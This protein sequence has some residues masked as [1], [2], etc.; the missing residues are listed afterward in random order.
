MK[1]RS[2][3]VALLFK[4]GSLAL[5]QEGSK[6]AQPLPDKSAV[7]YAYVEQENGEA[8]QVSNKEIF[9]RS[10]EGNGQDRDK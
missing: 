10:Q 7:A 4:I 3:L 5:A 2:L 8:W 6:S 1:M 9:D